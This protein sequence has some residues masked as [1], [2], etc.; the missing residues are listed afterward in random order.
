MLL[1]SYV[2]KILSKFR[3]KKLKNHWEK[4]C[5]ITLNTKILI[6]LSVNVIWANILFLW[7]SL[8]FMKD[9]SWP[10]IFL[11]TIIHLL[12]LLVLGSDINILCQ[13]ISML[14]DGSCNHVRSL[15][16]ILQRSSLP[17]SLFLSPSLLKSTL[18]YKIICT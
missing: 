6:K 11:K 10:V 17:L 15:F 5:F 2:T 13:I 16:L 4:Y 3:R 8:I 1:W 7:S 9:Q 14:L 12:L 18:T